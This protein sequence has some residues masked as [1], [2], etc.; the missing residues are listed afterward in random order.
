MKN[1]VIPADLKI[2]SPKARLV[3]WKA[4]QLRWHLYDVGEADRRLSVTT[5]P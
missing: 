5:S 1:T 3:G 4:R 2:D